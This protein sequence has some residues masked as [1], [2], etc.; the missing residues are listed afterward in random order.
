[1]RMADL[2]R[3]TALLVD[4]HAEYIKNISEVV[5]D[6]FGVGWAMCKG[7]FAGGGW[8]DG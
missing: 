2:P 7:R 8:M 6:V 1:M 3:S 5:G 4:K